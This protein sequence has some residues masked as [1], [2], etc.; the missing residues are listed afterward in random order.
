MSITT[1]GRARL[2]CYRTCDRRWPFLWATADQPAARWHG[3]G[4][5]PCQYLASSA[6]GA[7][8][9]TLR[10]EQITTFE[11]LL[12]LERSVWR[13]EAPDPSAR[14]RL[15]EATLTGDESTYPACRAEA[16][17]LRL[18]GAIGLVAPSAAVRSG[19]AERHGVDEHGAYVLDEVVTETVVIFGPPIDLV[20]MSV[21][22][23]H[24][25]PTF[26]GDVRHLSQRGSP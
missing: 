11:D 7:W 4:E 26:L 21:A 20:G 24:A 10:H 19:R 13:V 2:D 1:G 16:R 12:D 8:A 25:D 6:K 22:E 5:G 3:A 15:D 23:G 9:E 18:A 17:R 14:P